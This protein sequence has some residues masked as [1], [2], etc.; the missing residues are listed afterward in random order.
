LLLFQ[1]ALSIGVSGVDT[2]H[3]V[4]FLVGSVFPGCNAIVAEGTEGHCQNEG[5]EEPGMVEYRRGNA[6]SGISLTD[7]GSL[8]NV[9][10]LRNN[11]R[12][13]GLSKFETRDGCCSTHGEHDMARR[14]APV[15]DIRQ[16]DSGARVHQTHADVPVSDGGAQALPNRQRAEGWNM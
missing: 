3:S 16:Q 12:W 15:E 11:R 6:D 1:E 5:E 4:S 9:T 8:S 13:P 10:G 7:E 14:L 2:V